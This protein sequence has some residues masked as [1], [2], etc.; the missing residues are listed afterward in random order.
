MRSMKAPTNPSSS[1]WFLADPDGL[2]IQAKC[3]WGSCSDPATVIS[4]AM[5][6]STHATV[7]VRPFCAKHAKMNEMIGHRHAVTYV[8][9]PPTK[10]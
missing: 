4:I 3:D 10:D 9:Q 7:E 8:P 6:G 2:G 1:T 5:L